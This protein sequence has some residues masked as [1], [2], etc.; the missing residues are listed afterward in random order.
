D[1]TAGQSTGNKPLKWAE[2]VTQD[3]P[4]SG[5]RAADI[6]TRQAEQFTRA[7]LRRAGIQA[8]RADPP[9]LDA[10][11]LRLE[12]Q[13]DAVAQNVTIPPNPRLMADLQRVARDYNNLVA[14]NNR[15]PMVNQTV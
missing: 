1:L 10:G 7:V 12:Q 11:F 4:F 8:D 6:Q 2:A 14:P 13:L 5:K 3:I 9:T 15:G